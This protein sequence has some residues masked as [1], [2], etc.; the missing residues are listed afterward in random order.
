[1]S[2]FS[3]WNLSARAWNSGVV[4]RLHPDI[5]SVTGPLWAGASDDPPLQ[6]VSDRAATMPTPVA[7]TILRFM[8]AAPL[9]LRAGHRFGP[10]SAGAPR[11]G[12]RSL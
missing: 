4:L 1:M 12:L 11:A 7:T 6:A 8:R 9:R 10:E 2:G 5:D 3:S